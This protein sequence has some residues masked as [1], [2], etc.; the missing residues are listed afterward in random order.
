[1][2]SGNNI[3][4]LKDFGFW[5][6]C[7]VSV[8]VIAILAGYGVAGYYLKQHYENR[9]ERPGLT[10]T[11]IK[12]AYAGAMVP[13]PLLGKIESNHPE[14]MSAADRETLVTWLMSDTTK[15]DYENFDLDPMPSDVMFDNCVSCHARNAT[16]ETAFASVPLEYWDDIAPLAITR[17]IKPKDM[18]L[19][20]QSA[21][22]HVPSMA[23][24]LLGLTALAAITRW[25][26]LLVGVVSTGAGL[27]LIADF[28]AQWFARDFPQLTVVIVGGGALYAGAI[29]LL[30]FA[31]LLD[32]WLPGGRSGPGGRAST[33]PAENLPLNR[34]I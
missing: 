18:K 14:T 15:R 11:D 27:G 8:T 34:P 2:A 31:V 16:G 33:Q 23:I 22:A 32:C 21:H 30:G 10:M 4:R 28:G 26:G 3:P 13:S 17:E 5:V 6:R 29:A 25:P 19:V 7:G 12:G 24:V 20:V 9:D 1:M